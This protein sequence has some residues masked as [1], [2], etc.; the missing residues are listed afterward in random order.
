MC[1]CVCRV[2]VR[3]QPQRRRKA[4]TGAI[5]SSIF[6]H[7]YFYELHRAWSL[8][9]DFHPSARRQQV[10]DFL[11]LHTERWQCGLEPQFGPLGGWWTVEQLEMGGG[12]KNISR[13][14]VHCTFENKQGLGSTSK[15]KPYTP[16]S[17]WNGGVLYTASMQHYLCFDSEQRTPMLLLPW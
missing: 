2:Y 10:E 16:Q 3:A 14:P 13:L 5:H 6:K 15:D 7:S 1:V 17:D 9:P 12:K 11:W 4:H 8:L